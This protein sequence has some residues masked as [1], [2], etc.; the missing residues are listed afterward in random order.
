MKKINIFTGLRDFLILWS[1]QAVSGL[2]TAMTN[3]A[4]VIWTYQEG[5]TASSITLLTLCAFLP[6]IF[7]RF[8]AGAIADRLDKKKIMLLADLLAA[9]GTVTVLI[10]YSLSSLQIWHLYVINFLLSFMNAFQT[11]AA[12]VATSMLVPKEQYMRVGG[13]QSFSG[14]AVTILAPALGSVVL[15]FGGLTLVLVIDLLSF[16]VAFITLL[17]F[18]K[19]PKIEQVAEEIQEGIWKSCMAGINFLRKNSAL[20]RL[21]LYFSAVNFFAKIGG[22][23]MMAVFILGKSGNNQ[24][25][26]GLVEAA[27][28]LGILAGSLIVTFTKPAKNKV[29]VIFISAA[30]TFF[31]GNFVLSLMPS[32]PFWLAAA[33]LSY[34]PVAILGANLTTVM[35][36]NVPIEMQGRVFSA[37]DTLQNCTIPLGLLLGGILADY[38]FEPLMAVNSPVQQVLSIAFGSGKGSGVAIIFFIAGVLGCVISLAALRNPL[39]QELNTKDLSEPDCNL[40]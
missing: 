9:L 26:L 40:P 14:A 2:G 8:V 23:G 17:L 13:L 27:V 12:Y 10:L 24:V 18:I 38:V 25:A 3:F 22:D 5:G 31:L 16:A 7:F 15:A 21:I 32:L 35:R 28:S 1:S 34:I 37:R 20:L 11:P 39:Y 36:S 33:F 4:L 6:T 30:L 19:L 29:N